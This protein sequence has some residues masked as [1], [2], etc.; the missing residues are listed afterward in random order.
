MSERP[1]Y[2]QDYY[3]E[4]YPEQ[5]EEYQD[6]YPDETQ[7]KA[8]VYAQR[9]K[10]S[11]GPRLLDSWFIRL[12]LAVILILVIV[13]VIVGGAYFQ[14]SSSRDEPLEIKGFPGLLQ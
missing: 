6:D 1:E 10:E 13:G 8:S 4:E 2:P 14:A 12:L 9:E 5:R 3:E 7:D 11:D